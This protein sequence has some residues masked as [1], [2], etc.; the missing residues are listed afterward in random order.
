MTWR[1]RTVRNIRTYSLLVDRVEYSDC[2]LPPRC[3][4]T[5]HWA[6]CV[7]LLRVKQ[8][9]HSSEISYVQFIKNYYF[10]D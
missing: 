9:A 1:L 3:V 10:L 6:V 7:N 4:G 2:M 5:V 8:Y